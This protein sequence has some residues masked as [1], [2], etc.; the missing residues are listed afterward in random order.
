MSGEQHAGGNNNI[1][2]D[3]NSFGRA[4]IWGQT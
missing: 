4:N 1:K 2:T 3:N